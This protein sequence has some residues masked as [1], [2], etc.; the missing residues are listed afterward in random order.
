MAIPN[1]GTFEYGV[2]VCR[3]KREDTFVWIG[4]ARTLRNP[5]EHPGLVGYAPQLAL[6]DGRI[7][8]S[9][10]DAK[11][12]WETDVHY[13]SCGAPAAR[14]AFPVDESCERQLQDGDELIIARDRMARLTISRSRDHALLWE[15]CDGDS[16]QILHYPRPPMPIGDWDIMDFCRYP[17]WAG[18]GWAVDGYTFEPEVSEHRRTFQPIPGCRELDG[19]QRLL[20]P[21]LVMFWCRAVD[22]DQFR[23]RA[24]VS[25]WESVADEDS[26]Q[27]LDVQ[28]PEFFYDGT[29]QRMAGWVPHSLSSRHGPAGANAGRPC[30]PDD[31]IYPITMVSRATLLDRVFIVRYTSWDAVANVD[32]SDRGLEPAARGD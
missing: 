7:I 3:A 23:G 9:A 10:T 11:E 19:S 13:R 32:F 16:L 21:L 18:P 5:K 30:T 22:G 25:R 31:P 4:T 1:S 6:R 17:V 29:W 20:D 14:I 2:T 12:L 27:S 28:D 26:V 24:V 8:L 15:H